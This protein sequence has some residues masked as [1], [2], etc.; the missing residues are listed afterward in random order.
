MDHFAIHPGPLPAAVVSADL[1]RDPA[2]GAIASFIGVVRDH[3]RGRQVT[4]LHYECR[5]QLALGVLVRLAAALRARHDAG[6]R[7]TVVH[8]AGDLVPGDAAI[9]I[10]VRAAHRRGA[11]DACDEAIEAIKRDLPVWKR[12]RYADGGEEWMEGS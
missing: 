8:A 6:L 3:H 11:L 9:A 12:E 5:E 7:L 10:H 2:C 1:L 4:A